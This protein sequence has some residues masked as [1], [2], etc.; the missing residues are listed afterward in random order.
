MISQGVDGSFSER[1][2]TVDF[3]KAGHTW[4]P[5]FCTNWVQQKKAT[6]R[7]LRFLETIAE[8]R[9][10]VDEEKKMIS[11]RHRGRAQVNAFFQGRQIGKQQQSSGGAQ[12]GQ[13]DSGDT[14]LNAL[15]LQ[16][17]DSDCLCGQRHIFHDC[18]YLLKSNRSAGFKEDKKTRAFVRHKIEQHHRFFA[19]IRPFSDIGIL[20][21][22]TDDSYTDPRLFS[23]KFSNSKP[24]QREEKKAE[25]EATETFHFGNAHMSL[26]KMM[27]MA[28]LAISDDIDLMQQYNP[29]YYSVVHDSGCN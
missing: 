22:I 20:D 26:A 27:S 12:A 8:Y 28:N 9:E 3:L 7:P 18:P 19:C 13:S 29:L 23:K 24:K 21:G 16:Y 17:K 25:L 2:M 15:Y 11:G 6:G 1:R 14:D 5:N 4:A 10:A